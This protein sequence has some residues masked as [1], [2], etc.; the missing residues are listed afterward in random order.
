[1]KRLS[2]FTFIC[3]LLG[4]FTA[5]VAHS[6]SPG[7][8]IA[9]SQFATRASNLN[10]ALHLNLERKNTLYSSRWSG[11]CAAKY[12]PEYFPFSQ[13][14]LLSRNLQNDSR[15]TLGMMIGMSYGKLR[16]NDLSDPEFNFTPTWSKWAGFT[17]EIPMLKMEKR[18]SFYSEIAFSQFEAKSFVHFADS[19]LGHP[20]RDYYEIT[21][22]FAPNTI[23]ITNMF[24][25]CFTNSDFKYYVAA[26]IYNSFILSAVNTRSTVR[27]RAGETQTEEEE[28]IPD[29]SVHGLM[30][31]VSTGIAYKYTGLE[32]RYDPGRNYTRKVDYSVHQPS[33]VMVLHVRFNP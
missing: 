9:E 8:V 24:R 5:R 3:F 12:D 17:L 28:A 30:L 23:T 2:G 6:E 26:G 25:Y 27:F 1:M 19:S 14:A 13:T 21:Q 22:K 10:A 11:V 18:G 16:T 33:A 20:E 4:L 31:V 7:N 29:H 15:N 32:F